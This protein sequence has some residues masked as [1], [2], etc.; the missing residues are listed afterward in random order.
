MI[1]RK[2]L[3]TTCLATLVAGTAHADEKKAA[4]ATASTKVGHLDHGRWQLG[5]FFGVRGFSD[6]SGLGRSATPV[7]GSETKNAVPFGLR[8]GYRLNLRFSLEGELAMMGT[9]TVRSSAGLSIFDLRGQGVYWI[10]PETARLQPLVAA[11]LSVEGQLSDNDAVIDNGS[12]VLVHAGAGARYWLSEHFGVRLDARLL[13]GP[14][15]SGSFDAAH[16]EVLL[17]IYSDLGGTRAPTRVRPPET[18]RVPDDA[19]GDGIPDAQDDCPTKPEDLDGHNDDDGCPEPEEDVDSDGDGVLGSLDKCPDEKENVNGYQDEDGC[20]DTPPAAVAE[21]TGTIEG[22][23]F[24]SGSGKI[25]RKSYAVL[26]RVVKVL[27][28][29]PGLHVLV[30]GHTDNVGKRERNVA[31]SHKR[32]ESVKAYLVSKGIAAERLSAEGRGPDEP[33]E[34]NGTREGR[35][36][37]RRI[38]FQ[39]AGKPAE[40]KPPE[41]Q[42]P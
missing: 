16:G 29:N 15:T 20:V 38:E 5:G 33:L 13:L 27:N 41:K 17:S 8:L 11:G 19:D 28:E 22:I 30:I 24:G 39:I 10:L 40:K 3:V 31:L 18:P 6:D 1:R 4:E 26:D 35:A 36:A 9:E 2:I 32:A 12:V 23:S 7:P 21:F 42:A 37:N 34:D 25:T 14:S